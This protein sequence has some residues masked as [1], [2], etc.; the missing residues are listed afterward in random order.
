MGQSLVITSEF[1]IAVSPNCE[2]RCKNTLKLHE[3]VVKR[4]I[5]YLGTRKDV[6]RSDCPISGRSH[7]EF[8]HRAP[9]IIDDRDKIAEYE[10]HLRDGMSEA[11][12]LSNIISSPEII[13]VAE[14]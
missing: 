2:T 10:T 6:G 9:G 14:Q 8:I 1:Q 3:P 13:A 4:L 11:S 5:Y 7:A 12:D